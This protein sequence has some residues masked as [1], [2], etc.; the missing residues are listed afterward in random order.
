MY[1]IWR[2]N[3]CRD[4]VL[5][6]PSVFLSYFSFLLF[7]LSLS[8][9]LSLSLS[10]FL[11]VSLSL[12]LCLSRF[13]I[14]SLVR[15]KEKERTDRMEKN[16]S[17]ISRGNGFTSYAVKNRSIMQVLDRKGK[18]AHGEISIFVNI[19]LRRTLQHST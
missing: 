6:F 19:S 16:D 15:S 17:R 18:E 4:V 11:C 3:L 14:F 10:L 8:L 5:V 7:H 1:T 2:V 9:P 13:L 12:T